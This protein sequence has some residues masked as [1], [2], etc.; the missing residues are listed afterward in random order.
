[1]NNNRQ[2]HFDWLCFLIDM[3]TALLIFGIVV[4]VILLSQ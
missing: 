4:L 3:I 1:M 2:T